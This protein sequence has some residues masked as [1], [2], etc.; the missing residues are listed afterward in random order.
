[1]NLIAKMKKQTGQIG[2]TAEAVNTLLPADALASL[3]QLIDPMRER[4]ARYD[5]AIQALAIARERL[6]DLK[7]LPPPDMTLAVERELLV[8]RGD[9]EALRAFDAEYGEHLAAERAKRE[10]LMREREEL[11]ARVQA[12]ETL[13]KKIAGEMREHIPDLLRAHELVTELFKP[14]AKEAFEAAQTYVDAARRAHAAAEALAK[15]VSAYRYDLFGDF[16]QIMAPELYG[17]RGRNV[18]PLG[19]PGIRHE[20]IERL[21]HALNDID[22]YLYARLTSELDAAGLSGDQLRVYGPPAKEDTRRIYT[23]EHPTPGR[24]KQMPT[25]LSAAAAVETIHT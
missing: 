4:M 19:L 10:A 13:I 9:V 23:P 16:K 18:L 24:I 7:E 15:T 14:F 22:E 25:P 21:N 6:L 3:R 11:P 17:V 8:E 20:E 2:Q 1:M 12:L 5:E